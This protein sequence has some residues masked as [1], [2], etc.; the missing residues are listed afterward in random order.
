MGARPSP[1]SGPW[2][3]Q[4]LLP[5]LARDLTGARSCPLDGCGPWLRVRRGACLVGLEGSLE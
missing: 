2:D 4:T 3:A 5:Y 1:E